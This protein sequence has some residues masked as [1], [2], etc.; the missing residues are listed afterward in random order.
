M[1]LLVFSVVIVTALIFHDSTKVAQDF[2]P[3]AALGIMWVGIAWMSMVEGGQCAMVGLPP[4]SPELYKESH[5]ITFSICSLGHHGDNLDRY[6]MGRQFMVIFINF[7][8]HLCGAPMSEADSDDVLGLPPW[9]YQTFLRSGLAM[10]FIVVIIGQLTAQANAA[11]CMLD[12]INNHFMTLTLWVALL[13]EKTGILHSCYG[14]QYFCY[15][16]SQT[17]IVTQEPPRAPLQ[18]V[19]FWGRCIASFALLA[20][21]L[22]V[23][24]EGLVQGQT[25]LWVGIRDHSAGPVV[26]FFVLLAIVGMLEGMQIA[27]IAVSK[28]PI[29]ERGS[30][31]MAMKT[32]ELLFRGEGTN[33]PGFMYGRQI[34]VTLCFF[35]LAHITTLNVNLDNLDDVDPTTS[36]TIF[37]V[38]APVQQ[39]FNTGY[40]GAIVT[41]ILGS[42]SW[43]IVAST[44]PLAFLSNPL[45]YVFLRLAL[46]LEATGICAAASLLGTVHKY[47]VG[48]QLDEL[49][50]GTPGERAAMDKAD[51]SLAAG[52]SVAEAHLGTNILMK[53]PGAHRLPEEF[54]ESKFQLSS[55]RNNFSERRAR[56]LSNIKDLREQIQ[57]AVTPAET[58][59]FEVA[60][61]LEIRTLQALNQEQKEK[62]D[63][64]GVEEGAVV[65]DA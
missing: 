8:I 2:H 16:L 43:Q 22:A 35:I 13:I 49:Y 57:K 7:T 20:F 17:T 31:P 21:S 9:I 3:V 55:P 37:G 26:L 62:D 1:L 6:L 40:L 25:T 42:I 45:V 12:Y 59:A 28:L 56:I 61:A 52:D 65:D 29:H 15:W 4:V 44:F 32:C 50:I 33:L 5:A 63:S 53:S 38:S 36:K 39:F 64:L 34:L 27:F 41:T 48:L 30:H 11:Q 19:F 24:L 58:S 10:V 47:V 46:L 60:L 54:R 14:I 51:M 18:N 23:T